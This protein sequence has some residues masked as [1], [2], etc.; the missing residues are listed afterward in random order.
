MLT[1][2][3]DRNLKKIIFI[4]CI[5]S[6]SS[7]LF[8][9]GFG[10]IKG[11]VVDKYMGNPL[12]GANIIIINTQLGAITGIEGEFEIDKIAEGDYAFKISHLGHTPA[13][14]WNVTILEDTIVTVNFELRNQKN[15]VD[16][17]EEN[18][19]LIDYES[20]C[21]NPANESQSYSF[22]DGKVVEI[23]RGDIIVLRLKTLGVNDTIKLASIEVMPLG[24]VYGDSAKQVLID[25][26]MN[27]AIHVLSP[28]SYL[29]RT[30]TESYES[31][32]WVD[33]MNQI[34]LKKGLANYTKPT[35]CII[36]AYHKCVYQILER[37]SKK[38]KLGIWGNK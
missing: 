20:C 3:T 10:K 7:N 8:P 22:F 1:N 2:N 15:E 14:Y 6:F 24:T 4:I 32:G 28:T 36:S 33:E 17:I 37:K 35:N 23:I 27:K 21:G 12:V 26:F 29:K 5:V 34:L 18:T 25:N 11:K 9:H 19:F 13:F 30:D 16:T 31:I 38:E